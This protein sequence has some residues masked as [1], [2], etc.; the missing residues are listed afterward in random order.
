[1]L[2]LVTNSSVAP[3]R[4][5]GRMTRVGYFGLRGALG[6]VRVGLLIDPSQA[7]DCERVQP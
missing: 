5:I 6:R 4:M 1:M 3:K 2:C 7:C